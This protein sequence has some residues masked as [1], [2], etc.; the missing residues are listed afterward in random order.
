ME[1]AIGG[2]DREILLSTQ[3][4]CQ[5][6]AAAEDKIRG[7]R[8]LVKHSILPGVKKR[9]RSETPPERLASDNEAKHAEQEL[10]AAKR[11]EKVDQDYEHTSMRSSSSD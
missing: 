2:G 3:Q 4:L 6:L 1:D 8:A 9:K 5:Y 7:Q 11:M 10:R